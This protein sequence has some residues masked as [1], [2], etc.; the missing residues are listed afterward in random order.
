MKK[1][2]VRLLYACSTGQR[3]LE[4]LLDAWMS[5]KLPA[6]LTSVA[7]HISPQIMHRQI[8]GNT[9][10]Q[11]RRQ[12]LQNGHP[13]FSSSLIHHQLL[14]IMTC[15]QQSVRWVL[16]AQLQSGQSQNAFALDR[17]IFSATWLKVQILQDFIPWNDELDLF[18][19]Q[20]DISYL[21]RRFFAPIG[22]SDDSLQ[23]GRD[24][25]D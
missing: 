17:W 6:R 23:M 10:L 20:I 24:G 3:V 13:F 22:S 7:K 18:I 11:A 4:Q 21:L 2:I 8:E 14:E 19:R 5:L 25:G 16:K 1:L 12:S 15:Y 9:P